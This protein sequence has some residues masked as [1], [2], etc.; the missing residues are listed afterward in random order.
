ML[1]WFSNI[2]P[3]RFHF[4]LEKRSHNCGS[5]TLHKERPTL[6]GE[7]IRRHTHTIF[8]IPCMRHSSS[9]RQFHQN[10]HMVLVVSWSNC[11]NFNQKFNF[12]QLCHWKS[13]NPTSGSQVTAISNKI[14]PPSMSRRDKMIFSSCM[15]Q[16]DSNVT[17]RV[18]TNIL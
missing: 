2:L 11:Q 13:Q 18:P 4:K 8:Y 6:T 16:A 12:K 3:S 14:C 7:G 17:I 15:V 1:G 10:H 5:R 9:S